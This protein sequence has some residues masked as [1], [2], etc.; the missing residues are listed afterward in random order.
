[1]APR[2]IVS[3]IRANHTCQCSLHLQHAQEL[4]MPCLQFQYRSP[5]LVFYDHSQGGVVGFPYPMLGGCHIIPTGIL[6][7][8]ERCC[9]AWECFCGLLSPELPAFVKINNTTDGTIGSCNDCRLYD[10][11]VFDCYGANTLRDNSAIQPASL[12]DQVAPVA[13]WHRAVHRQAPYASTG[14]RCRSHVQIHRTVQ[15]DS[16]ENESYAPS[17]SLPSPRQLLAGIRSRHPDTP[18]KRERSPT[19]F[20]SL[21]LL[22]SSTAAA[23]ISSPYRPTASGSPQTHGSSA[24]RD[25][26]LQFCNSCFT[27]YP[28]ESFATHECDSD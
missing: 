16:D 18:I 6:E 22:T 26:V 7:Y 20:L 21:S 9:Q 25:E 15:Q 3:A 12:P 19:Q 11:P 1:M 4:F 24:T 14:P 8:N 2:R 17:S 27:A 23:L 10:Y 13:W 5:N 28:V